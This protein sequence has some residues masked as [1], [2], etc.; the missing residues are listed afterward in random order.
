MENDGAGK[1]RELEIIIQEGRTKV[2]LNLPLSCP[3][4]FI[5]SRIKAV[6]IFY[7]YVNIMDVCDYLKT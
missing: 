6:Q 1:K 4:L 2:F 5:K 3:F 7:I